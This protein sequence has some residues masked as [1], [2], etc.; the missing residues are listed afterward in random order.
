LN[1]FYDLAMRVVV[2]G[3]VFGFVRPLV[4]AHNLGINYVARLLSDCGY[5][6]IIADKTVTNTLNYINC[7]EN[8]G[9]LRY[10]ICENAITRLG[11]SYRLDPDQAQEIF[12]R[13]YYQLNNWR[14]LAERG[15][16]IRGVYFAGLPMACERIRSEYEGKIPVFPGDESPVETLIKLGVPPYHIPDSLREQ[17]AHDEARLA[18][19]RGVIERETYKR[20]Q[21]VNRTGVSN[22]GTARER[23]IDRLQH[24]QLNCLPPLIRVHVGPFQPN[25]EQAVEQFIDWLHQLS[26]SGLLDIVSI[27]TSQLTQSHFGEEWGDFPNGGGVPINSEDEYRRVWEAARPMLVRTYAG[28][29][30][31]MELAQIHERSLHMAWHALS[32]WWFSQIDGRGANTVLDNLREHLETLGFIGQS[33]KPF[34]PNIPHHFAF[35]GSDDLSYILSAY[36][37]ARTAKKRGIRYL[38]LQNMLNTPK[39]TWGIQDLAKSRA[40]LKLVRELQDEKFSVILQPRGGLDYFSLDT[41]KA[42]AQLAAV[43][44]LMDD[45]EPNNELSPPIIHVV[46][47]SEATH[48]ADPPV[49]NESI[50]I[51]RQALYEY[52]EQ[53]RQG[54]IP[55]SR[56]LPDVH[57]RTA[58]LYE[59]T[60]EILK[61][62]EREIKDPYSPEGLYRIFTAGF[63]PV[64]F[65][66]ECR[67]EFKHAI[68]W[69]TEIVNGGIAVI[70]G[71]GVP[72]APKVR[73]EIA[74]SHLSSIRLDRVKR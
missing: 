2:P 11:L 17:A 66:W 70:D 9:I 5:R 47:Y 26:R 53:K 44:T 36:L 28:T 21:P 65:L 35:R 45:I 31:I 19:G 51:V 16:I 25:R 58:F 59:G 60:R 43:C 41:N 63:L 29:H 30:R 46:N 1:E 49:I 8:V 10:W 39:Y 24:S 3:E 7:L 71:Q 50:Q 72:I 54:R 73:A 52:R 15:G 55:D 22:F 62:I 68:E 13:F 23:L 48:L 18:F 20:I 12:G 37:A 57:Q 4:D 32:F 33:G 56:D 6:S 27:G 61:V 69:Q 64:P 40:M 74:A 42:K 38:I 14:L 34:E 67:D